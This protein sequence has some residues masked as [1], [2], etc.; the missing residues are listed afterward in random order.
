[1]LVLFLGVRPLAKALLKKRDDATPRPALPIGGHHRR[2][3]SAPTRRVASTCSQDRGNSYDDRV[4]L[5]R[6]FTRDNP[7]RAALAVRDMIKADAAMNALRS[8]NGVERAAVLMMLVGEEEA[9][10]IL[11]K[12]DP[13]EVRDLGKA[14]FT[15]ADVSEAEVEQVLDD[16][17]F[18]ARGRSGVQF[19]PRAADRGHD[20]QGARPSAPRACSRGSCRRQARPAR[21]IAMVRARRDRGDDRGGAS[22]DRR[23]AA[24][25]A[26]S[27]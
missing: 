2:R 22:A 13:D 18:K 1:L 11:Q 7:A 24:R 8:F 6:G 10:A 9:A 23:G 12:L 26:R 3:A 4:G 15:V 25:P 5:V 21:A 16:F 20:D 14:M 27:R 17:V 19:D